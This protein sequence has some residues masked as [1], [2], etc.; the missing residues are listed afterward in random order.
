M[1]LDPDDARLWPQGL[2][3]GGDPGD[4][5]AADLDEDRVER[6]ALLAHDLHPYR[7]LAG[8]DVLVVAGR[9]DD[10]PLSRVSRE[11]LSEQTSM[12]PRHKA[13]ENER[14]AGVYRL[15]EEGF[16]EAAA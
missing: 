13:A 4:E 3:V 16:N 5:A 9:D 1:R 10:H 15:T 8:D 11:C 7:T 14:V 2:D 6:L 12:R